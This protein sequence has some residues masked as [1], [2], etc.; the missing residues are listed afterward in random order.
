MEPL[1]GFLHCAHFCSKCF[2]CFLAY[3][4]SALVSQAMKVSLTK[5]NK[6]PRFSASTEQL[7]LNSKVS[8]IWKLVCIPYVSISQTVIIY[9]ASIG[10][11][12]ILR[13][14]HSIYGYYCYLEI[15]GLFIKTVW[16]PNYSMEDKEFINTDIGIQP[17]FMY[18][19]WKL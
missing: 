4:D 16:S 8:L 2:A 17:V 11:K 9:Q 3:R 10:D 1:I 7:C 18:Y 15:P 14:S 13:D 12:N 19:Y 5:I 6:C